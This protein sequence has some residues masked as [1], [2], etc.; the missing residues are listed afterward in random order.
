MLRK[1]VFRLVFFL[2]KDEQLV[3]I[4]LTDTEVRN[5]W[6]RPVKGVEK[7]KGE[8]LD[9]LDYMMVKDTL[10]GG[11]G[12]GGGGEGGGGEGEGGVGGSEGGDVWGGNGGGE[13][14]G[15]EGGAGSG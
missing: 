4:Q 15:G 14:G 3:I 2:A 9:P 12:E 7:R 10:T 1:A 11:R 8:L 13:G 6:Y 5:S